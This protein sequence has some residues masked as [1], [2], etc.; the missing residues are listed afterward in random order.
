MRRLLIF[1]V[2]VAAAASAALLGGASRENRGGGAA[3][4]PRIAA[5]LEAGLPAGTASELVRDLQERLLRADASS[6]RDWV[7]LGLGYEQLARETGDV[8][9]YKKAGAALRRARELDRR[10][11]T[12]VVALG[13]LALSQHRFRRALALGLH[14]QFLAPAEARSYGVV[15]DALIEL[16]RYNAALGAFRR[17]LDLKPTSSA[18]ARWSYARELVGDRAGAERWMRLARDAAVGQREPYAWAAV[19]LGN[20]HWGSGRVNAA[21]LQY[22]LALTVLPGYVY[23]LDGLA[24]VA[25]AGGDLETALA[26]EEKAADT[27][28]LPQFVAQLGDLY[29]TSGRG[30]EA[31]EQYA[32]VGAIERLQRASGVATDLEAAAFR[33]DHGWP[34]VALARRA[35]AARPSIEGD[36]VL[37][38][39]LARA[40]RCDEA[41]H[42]S[43]R[44][45]RLGTRDA[46]KFF[47]RAWIEDCL[48]NRPQARIWAGRALR[49][50]PH[51][52]LLWTDAAR[53]LAA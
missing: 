2:V 47:H 15:G 42:W 49:L 32:T 36:D 13:S 31:R 30:R 45:L 28:P 6:T 24:R 25:A 52:S 11:P 14:A 48:G 21:E 16:G 27:I 17:M 43:G 26:L 5:A 29:R 7:L 19:Q 23:A 39:T 33:A 35:H 50:N 3:A 20:L 1:L 46:L 37:A 12:A 4:T 53:R 44:A 18:Y 41:A 10:D 8:A 40:G 9:F 22:R 51:F 34:S 38:W